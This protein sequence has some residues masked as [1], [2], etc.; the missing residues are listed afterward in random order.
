MLYYL[1]HEHYTNVE[2]FTTASHS[3]REQDFRVVCSP[4]ASVMMMPD[5]YSSPNSTNKTNI[6]ALPHVSH[7]NVD[8]S[9]SVPV[10][11]QSVQVLHVFTFFGATSRSPIFG[12]P[13]ELAVAFDKPLHF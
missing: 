5:I 2:S 12:G 11:P 4:Q 8:T 6:L 9:V 1:F 3:C 13:R 7:S 10:S